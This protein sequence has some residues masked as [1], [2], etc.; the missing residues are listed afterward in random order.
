MKEFDLEFF[1]A[2]RREKMDNTDQQILAI[3]KEN[4][5]LTNKE[6]GKIVHLTG[7][8][9][10]TRITKLR[11]KGRIARFSIDINYDQTQFIRVFMD[12]N[13]YTPFERTINTYSEVTSFYKVSGQACY[14]I[15][16][17]FKADQLAEFI[18]TV[19]KWGRY[20]VETVVADRTREP[21]EYFD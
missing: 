2:E 14:M 12:S 7:Q 5:Q 21:I 18:E 20:S 15:I 17:H 16:A 10:G 1:H 13:R 3:L 8:A 4:S 19:S 11:E 9:V 6:I